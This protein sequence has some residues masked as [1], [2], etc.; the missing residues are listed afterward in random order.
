M[1]KKI[2]QKAI[3]VKIKNKTFKVVV[4]QNKDTLLFSDI[5]KGNVDRNIIFHRAKEGHISIGV[6][7]EN[8]RKYENKNKNLNVYTMAKEQ[9]EIFD[10]WAK[11]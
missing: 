9:V 10:K 8:R 4:S 1:R 7:I 5:E 11:A 2:D 3:R 6:E